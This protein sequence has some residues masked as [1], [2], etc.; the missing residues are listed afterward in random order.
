MQASPGDDQ[1][2]VDPLSIA[3]TSFVRW[4]I[5]LFVETMCGCVFVVLLSKTQIFSLFVSF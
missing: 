2:F 4:F 5:C 3:M 1:I